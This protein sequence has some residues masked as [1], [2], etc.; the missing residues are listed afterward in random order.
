MPNSTA[1]SRVGVY[2]DVANLTLNG[3]FGMRYDVLRAFACRGSAEA[4]RL[5]AYV[6]FDPERA[7]ADRDYQSSQYRFHSALRDVGFKVIAKETKWYTNDA[8]ERMGKA[9]IDMI[10]AVDALLQ[11]EK[12]DRV[13][14]A[15]GD[16]DFVQVV[17]ALQNRGCRVEVIGFDNV[18]GDLRREADLYISGYLIPNLL[19]VRFEGAPPSTK[20]WGEMDSY[21]RGV[22]YSHDEEKG[23]GWV[24]YLKTLEGELWK[25]DTRDPESPY[26]AIFCHDSEIPDSII[27]KLPSRNLIFQFQVSEGQEPGQVKAVDVE[28]IKAPT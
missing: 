25:T 7:E 26:D 10:L 23:F 15:T 3:G 6:S 24:R 18:S 5:N 27:P 4:L 21:V 12:L 16:G 17:N 28:I 11:S 2:V 1:K 22:C 9:N 20:K 8:G 19:P 14:I 13:V